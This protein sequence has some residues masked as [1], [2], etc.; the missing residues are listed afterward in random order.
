M[1]DVLRVTR[2]LGPAECVSLVE[3]LRAAAG[4]EAPVYGIGTGPA[5]VPRARKATLIDVSPATR[6]R[7]ARRLFAQ[8]SALERHFDV[9]LER[10]EPPQFL[11]Y[12]VGDY[13]VA[14]Q[15]G[16]TPMIRD[17]SLARRVSAVVF[18]SAQA[19]AKTGGYEGGALVLHG[20]PSAPAAPRAIE[21]QPGALVAFR[22]E[23]T[24]E[25]TPVTAGERYT[26]VT[27]YR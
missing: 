11:R 2:F 9:A 15:D 22:S 10:C 5:V 24:H 12:V 6:D 25:V 21:A 26:V 4:L 1:V 27:W 3:E 23:T 13:F 19:S 7:I 8:K 20:P 17:D 14:H 16:N 18:L